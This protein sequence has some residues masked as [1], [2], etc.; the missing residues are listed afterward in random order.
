MQIA[1]NS[2]GSCV[3]VNLTKGVSSKALSEALTRIN[4]QELN[5]I[6]YESQTKTYRDETSVLRNNAQVSANNAN[7]SATNANNSALL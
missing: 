4:E 3:K 6:G 5:I 1:N 2:N 7:T